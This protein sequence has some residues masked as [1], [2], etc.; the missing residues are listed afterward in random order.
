MI[1]HLEEPKHASPAKRI[2]HAV[3]REIY[4]RYFMTRES[5][6]EIGIALGFTRLTINRCIQTQRAALDTIRPGLG[7]GRRPIPG[8]HYARYLDRILALYTPHADRHHPHTASASAADFITQ[9]W[10]RQRREAKQK[11]WMNAMKLYQQYC[12][13]HVPTEQTVSYKTFTRLMHQIIGDAYAVTR[14][15]P[16][17]GHRDSN[18]KEKDS[19]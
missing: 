10:K 9:W 2:T 1:D 11:R 19:S 13:S 5:M 3:Y 15:R 4:V 17:K 16:A 12:S 14:G 8:R 6:E 18:Q 7:Q